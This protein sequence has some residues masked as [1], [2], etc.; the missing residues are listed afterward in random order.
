MTSDGASEGG[1]ARWIG[2]ATVVLALVVGSALFLPRQS[3]WLDEATQMSGL[4][5]DPARVVRWLLGTERFN[6]GQ[7]RDRTPPLSYWL[8]W[9]WSRAFG[10]GEASFRWFGVVCVAV[11]SALVFEAGRLAFGTVAGWAA[12]LAFS[13]SPAV[14]MLAVEIRA[15]PLFLL[16]SASAWYLLVRW[17]MGEDGPSWSTQTALAL[18]LAAAVGTHYFGVVLSGGVLVALA[19]LDRRRGR[20]LGPVVGVGG[21]VAVA[22]VGIVPFI[23]TSVGLYRYG[24]DRFAGTAR[25]LN[26]LKNLLVGQVGHVTLT[27][28]RPV[29]VVALV[30][31]AA[32]VILAIWSMGT[33]R[34]RNAGLAVALAL[35]AGFAAVAVAKLA[36]S[37]FDPAT[38]SYNAWMRPGMCLLLASGVASRARRTAVACCGALIVAQGFGVYQLA[39]HGEHFAHGPHRAISGMIR[40][41]GPGEVAVVHDDPSDRAI[42]LSSPIR[43]EWGP[44][45]EQYRLVASPGG[46]AVVRGY[47][48]GRETQTIGSLPHRYLLVVSSRPMSPGPWR[49]RCA[50]ETGP[51]GGGRSRGSSSRRTAGGSRAGRSSSRR[52]P[53]RS[54]CSRTVGRKAPAPAREGR[55]MRRV[56]ELDALRGV[57]A[58]G[59]LMFHLRFVGAFPLLRTC[60]DLF[61]VLSG[62]LITTIILTQGDAPGFLRNFYARRALRIWP[63][64]YLTLVTFVAGNAF[65]P[66]PHHQPTAGLPYY[67]SYTQFI[68]GYWFAA[69]PPL[70]IYLFEH[71]WTLAAEEQFYLIWPLLLLLAGRRALVPLALG[72]VACP[73]VLRSAGL[74]PNMLL[75]H[76]DGLALG[77]LLAALLHDRARFDRHRAAFRLGFVLVGAATALAPSWG[78]L[79][80]AASLAEMAHRAWPRIDPLRMEASLFL[81]RAAVVYTC[82]V[83]LVVCSAGHPLLAPLRRRR[84][85]DVGSISYGLYLYHPLIFWVVGLARLALGFRGSVWV[86][87]VRVIACFAVAA[88]SWRFVEQPLLKLKGRFT[89]NGRPASA[90]IGGALKGPHAATGPRVGEARRADPGG[91]VG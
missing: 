37:R 52:S 25:R 30:A 7:L 91:L 29:E 4:S 22:V 26:G 44:G 88:L 23:R 61:F 27:V 90:G 50:P 80:P 8:G 51:S 64:Y 16:W 54:T 53:P 59:I 46:P 11:A 57:A 38:P 2:L 39:A 40:R 74:R 67:L 36:M 60:V 20:R 10:Y 81:L 24:P 65:L 85:G 28:V 66:P 89:Y 34:R 73:V 35:G 77:G 68:P 14:V 47:P 21:V 31:A 62:Y 72:F 6:F 75:T 45:L 55:S 5:L 87:V 76:S 1:A 84:L 12:G 78:R 49:R 17:Q 42:F 79:L 63:I 15:Y 86:D 13:L 83:G 69:T 71:T 3:L 82:L 70:G 33:V 43:C 18:V 41:V 58:V 19:V 32:L 48:D 9:A 56:P